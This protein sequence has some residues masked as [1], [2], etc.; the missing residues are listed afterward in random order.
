MKTASSNQCKI[1]IVPPSGTVIVSAAPNIDK[2]GMVTANMT[3][4]P[5]TVAGR[6]AAKA[7][8]PDQAAITT[9]FV[10][11]SGNVPLPPTLFG[12]DW[13]GE[14]VNSVTV[15]S[16]PETFYGLNWAP[17]H[18]DLFLDSVGGRKLGEAW[19]SPPHSAFQVAL[20]FP[21]R[22]SRFETHQIVALQQQTQYTATCTVVY[23]GL[24]R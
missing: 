7:S 2:T 18:I 11:T 5:G 17:L 13:R 12:R 9:S 8:I 1:D 24:P 16:R 3:I 22:S 4:P 14:P 6:Y 23:Q 20:T 21:D 15:D 19:G 10:I